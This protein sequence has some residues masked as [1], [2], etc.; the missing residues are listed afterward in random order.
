MEEKISVSV[1]SLGCSKNQ[2]D[3]EVMLYELQAGGFKLCQDPAQA[4]VIVVNTCGFIDDAKEEAVATVLEMAQYKKTGQ[5][6]VLAVSGCLSQRYGR[7]L[8][9][10]LPEVDIFLGVT[11]YPEIVLFVNR[12]LAGERVFDCT[13]HLEVAGSSRRVLTTPPWMAYLKIAEGCDNCCTYCAI[14]SI[15]GGFRSRPMEELVE[16]AAW[17]SSQGVREII[18]VAQDITRYGMD[19]SGISLLPRLLRNLCAIEGIHWVRLMYCYPELVGEK[20][21][22]VIME[23]PKICCY[24]DIPVQHC[25]SQVL[26]AMNRRGSSDDIQK[27][28]QKIKGLSEWIALRTSLIVGFPGETEAAFE[29]LLAFVGEGRF[30]HLGAFVY[31]QEEGTAAA[32]LPD[33]VLRKDKLKR[34]GRIM[35]SQQMVSKAWGRRMVGTC[36]EVLVEGQEGDRWVGRTQYHAPD[37][38]GKV[39]FDGPPNLCPGEFVWVRIIETNEYDWI[40]VWENEPGQ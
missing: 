40:G 23:E 30:M 32:A 36:H 21:L 19:W 39:F 7:E 15:R 10:E 8:Q 25:N 34:Y 11:Q 38:D 24:M 2:A 9:E 12:A 27:L 29:E 4:Q 31:S 18:V 3:A 13:L 16:E 6:R 20:L 35:R 17:L 22:S 33:Q 37:I 26:S 5:C 1:V 14:P 28:F